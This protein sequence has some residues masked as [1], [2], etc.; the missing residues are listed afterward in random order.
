MNEITIKAYQPSSSIEP[1][2]MIFVDN[3]PLD[4]VL[5]I[6]DLEGLYPAISNLREVHDRALAIERF[7]PP[8]GTTSYAPILICGDDTDFNCTVVIAEVKAG[9]QAITW[10]RIGTDSSPGL[11]KP[12]YRVVGESVDWIT[13]LGPFIFS[14]ENYAQVFERLI[15]E[16]T[17]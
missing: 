5:G 1:Y 11:N 6:S 10:N 8:P 12:P 16:G 13:G 4:K 3:K 14:R 15:T 2:L 17:P 9:V 7:L